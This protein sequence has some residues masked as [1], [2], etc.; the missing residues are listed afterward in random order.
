MSAHRA[1]YQMLLAQAKRDKGMRFA[2]DEDYTKEYARLIRKAK[3]HVEVVSSVRLEKAMQF[4][5]RT[6]LIFFVIWLI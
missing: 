4:S 2:P 5:N 6:L 3:K 1:G